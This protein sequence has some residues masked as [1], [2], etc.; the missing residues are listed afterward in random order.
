MT[1]SNAFFSAYEIG[2]L[3]KRTAYIEILMRITEDNCE[4]ELSKLSG[5]FKDNL[6]KEAREM[7]D[8]IIIW[9]NNSTIEQLE[10]L[11]DRVLFG[12]K[13]VRQFISP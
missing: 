3:T 10:K 1:D 2:Q 6:L 8:D 11:R 13:I 9:Q 12:A 7:P 4:E 5:E